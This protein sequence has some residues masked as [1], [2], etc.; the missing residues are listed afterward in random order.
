MAGQAALNDA[1]QRPASASASDRSD[2]G[3]EDLRARRAGHP[4]CPIAAGSAARTEGVGACHYETIGAL[5]AMAS[6]GVRRI[7]AAHLPASR[8]GRELEHR[9]PRAAADG[10]A[11][12]RHDRKGRD[13]AFHVHRSDWILVLKHLEEAPVVEARDL[14]RSS[15]LKSAWL[16]AR[17]G[18]ARVAGP[19][20]HA[21]IHDAYDA[22]IAELGDVRDQ[23]LRAKEGSRT[24]RTVDNELALVD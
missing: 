19:A 18:C 2:A 6:I 5:R 24:Q 8:Q 14:G 15:R 11:E 20:L 16:A 22:R 13:G 9:D 17:D 12:V 7:T 23:T 21:C 4:G 1:V 10:Q 3:R